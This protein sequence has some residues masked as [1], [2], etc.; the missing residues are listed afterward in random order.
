M[1]IIGKDGK[2]YTSVEEC[3]KAEK[4]FD[5]AVAAEKRKKEELQKSRKERAQKVEDAYKAMVDAR[6]AYNEE[7]N[8]FIKD[9]GSFH[10][11][12]KTGAENPFNLFD[13]VFDILF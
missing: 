6:T 9:F 7:L 8:K 2:E 12:I 1:K 4:A 11:T 13:K 3:M 10:Y 5:E